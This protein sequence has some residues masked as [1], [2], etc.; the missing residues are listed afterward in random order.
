MVRK[1]NSVTLAG[2]QPLFA[3]TEPH[4]LPELGPERRRAPRLRVQLPVKVSAVDGEEE[5]LLGDISCSGCL[6][7]SLRPVSVGQAL[8]IEA[9]GTRFGGVVARVTEVTPPPIGPET[10]QRIG[11]T[12]HKIF[13]AGVRFVAPSQEVERVIERLL[14]GDLQTLDRRQESRIE[15]G[16]RTLAISLEAGDA[17][18]VAEAYMQDVSRGGVF[19]RTDYDAHIGESLTLRLEHDGHALDLI[20]CVMHKRS[21][22]GNFGLGV[23]LDDLSEVKRAALERFTRKI[24]FADAAQPEAWWRRVTKWRGW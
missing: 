21:E 5:E 10:W 18:K 6:I 7:Y 15:L 12:R 16:R 20:G 1:G 8:T 11:K 3:I 14:T 17:V 23:R 22:A 19:L 4:P 2:G 9:Q 13:A 24:V